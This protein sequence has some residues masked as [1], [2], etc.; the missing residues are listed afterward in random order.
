MYVDPTEHGM[1]RPGSASCNAALALQPVQWPATTSAG[2][3][4]AMSDTVG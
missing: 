2:F 4:A 1:N 3:K